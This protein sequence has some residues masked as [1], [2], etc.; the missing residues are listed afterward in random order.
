MPWLTS[1]FSSLT[2]TYKNSKLAASSSDF[3]GFENL[4]SP[5]FARVNLLKVSV[6]EYF[7]S[8]FLRQEDKNR[9]LS[10]YN[11]KTASFFV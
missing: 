1:V 9:C 11:Y 6:S 5:A 8:Q 2:L 7:L 3:E 10:I 4:T